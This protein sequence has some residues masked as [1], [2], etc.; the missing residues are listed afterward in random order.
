MLDLPGTNLDERLRT[1]SRLEGDIIVLSVEKPTPTRSDPTGGAG[2]FTPGG[3]EGSEAESG[4]EEISDGPMAPSTRLKYSR[5]Q[6]DER[7]D[8]DEWSCEFESI[9][10]TNEEDSEAKRRI[11]QGLLKGEAL[12]WYIDVPEE[13]MD[14]WAEFVT[15]FLKT[16]RE[17][18]HELWDG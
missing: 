1:T 8:V 3:A 6:G 17:A 7:H 10:T 2:F 5:F 15:L 14:N 16:F 18:R 11:F 9:A 4:E 12:K 13:T